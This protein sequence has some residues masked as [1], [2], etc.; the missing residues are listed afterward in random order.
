[1]NAEGVG[2]VSESG[3]CWEGVHER[4]EDEGDDEAVCEG[5]KC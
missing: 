5:K 3:C 1:V 4:F 2:V